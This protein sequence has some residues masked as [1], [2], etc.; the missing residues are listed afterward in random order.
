MTQPPLF[1]TRPLGFTPLQDAG[2]VP[3][4]NPLTEQLVRLLM[5]NGQPGGRKRPIA[6]VRKT[7]HPG[8]PPI[9]IHPAL[10]Q[11]LASFL[12]QGHGGRGFV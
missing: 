7:F 8:P 1:L 10:Q 5:G 9:Q 6:P 2:G 12:A 3:Q 4:F 11:Y